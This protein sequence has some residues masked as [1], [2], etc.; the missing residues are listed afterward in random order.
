VS[1]IAQALS[2][3]PALIREMGMRIKIRL[4]APLPNRWKWEIFDEDLSKL[5]R[6]SH[7]S[8]E[9]QRDAYQAGQ[10]VLA[11]MVSIHPQ[12]GSGKPH[13]VASVAP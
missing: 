3:N 6:A 13:L 2:K 11:A 12:T 5:I 9:F 10:A 1:D 7:L 8:Y 4:R